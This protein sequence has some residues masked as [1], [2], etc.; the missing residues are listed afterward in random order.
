MNLPMVARRRNI[1]VF[2]KGE[3]KSSSK[4]KWP[5]GVEMNQLIFTVKRSQ[6]RSHHILVTIARSTNATRTHTKPTE[7]YS[8]DVSEQTSQTRAE[9]SSKGESKS[10][11]CRNTSCEAAVQLYITSRVCSWKQKL[12]RVPP[13]QQLYSRRMLLKLTCLN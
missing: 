9:C 10:K 11:H 6:R 1:E 12:C 13:S 3:K 8:P 4:T 2:R 5:A 7:C